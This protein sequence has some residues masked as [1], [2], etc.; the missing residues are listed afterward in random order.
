MAN[1]PRGHL[2]GARQQILACLTDNPDGV[3]CHTA[4]SLG[5]G[6]RSASGWRRPARRP[7]VV[8][9]R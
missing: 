7:F 2:S 9:D 3:A 4:Q 6:S 1:S 5:V 8:P